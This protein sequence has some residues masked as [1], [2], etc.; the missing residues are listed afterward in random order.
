[1]AAAGR[2]LAQLRRIGPAVWLV[3]IG[4]GPVGL[5]FYL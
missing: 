1:M 3:G 4:I 2:G 5:A